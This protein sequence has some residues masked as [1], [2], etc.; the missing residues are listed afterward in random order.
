MVAGVR[1]R[2]FM[3]LGCPV[4][5]VADR[6]PNVANLTLSRATGRAQEIAIRSALGAGRGPGEAVLTGEPRLQRARRSAGLALGA[7][8]LAA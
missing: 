4:V 7:A 5:L 3:L 6:L 8:G 1:G 2:L